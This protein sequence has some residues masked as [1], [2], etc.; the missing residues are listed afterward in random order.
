MDL[1]NS[2][3]VEVAII[4]DKTPN[5]TLLN[6]I[7]KLGG[8][9][10]YI[11]NGDQVFI[12]FNL[13]LPHGFPTNT[14]FDILKAIIQLCSEAGAK[15]IYVGSFPFKGITIKA[16]SDI[17]GLKIYFESIGAE[18]LFL[19][20]SN[21]FFM[22][23]FDAKK[24]KVIKNRSYS[25]VKINNK[26]FIVPRVILDSN[27]FISINQ[28]NVDPLFECRL[29][30][31]NSYSIIPNNYQEIHNTPKKEKD[32]LVNDQYKQ[33]LKSNIIDVFGIKK[34]DLII[35][36]LFYILEGAGPYI[37]KDSNLKK[38]SIM[39]LGNDA[40]AVDAV[41]SKL[42]NLN[43]YINDL[44]LD[45]EEKRLG[46]A[47]IS[48]IR[49]LGENLE[50][51]K[52]EIRKCVNKLEEIKL[53]SFSIKTGQFCSGCFKQAYHLL[54]LM[55]TNMIKDLKYITP[56]NSVLIGDNPP[57]PNNIGKDNIILFGE[58]AI[59]STRKR[60]FKIIVKE[61]K[62]KRKYKVN[63]KVLKLTGCPPDIFKCI[64]SLIDYYGKGDVPMLNLYYNIIS[65]YTSE[66]ITK[67]LRKWEVL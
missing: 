45:A 13:E 11:N 6:G 9:S 66:E 4:K 47:Q 17:L 62:K 61:S 29:S 42:L 64:K 20:N 54:N 55:K 23:S 40:V 19:D 26:I 3:T 63:K 43:T 1:I 37:Y 38:T 48:K 44:I 50:E 51:V 16:I 35:N 15:K 49:M 33:I 12:K 7:E 39:V 5:E 53:Q 65:S 10:K 27:K 18:L 14:N 36:D 32:F 67:K 21:Y 41:T 22:K 56:Y 59:N 60:K 34:P 57:D 2:E 28:V 30:L 58:C 52:F 31:L 8:I 25:K 24:L 46:I